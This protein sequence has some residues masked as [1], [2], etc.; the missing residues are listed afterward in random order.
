VHR[1]D[2]KGA[3]TVTW[4]IDRHGVLAALLGVLA[5]STWVLAHARS[6]DRE[7]RVRLTRICLLIALQGALGI[8]QYQLELPSELVW[9][10]VCLA[11]LVWVGIVLT[12][13]QA[14]SPLARSREE[15]AQT[16]RRS[17]T[18]VVRS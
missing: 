10:H 1:L 2:F 4:I 18:P 11:T 14:G 12:A 3:D 7:L 9:V 17:L 5:V 6:A 15:T 16:G 8:V 13:V